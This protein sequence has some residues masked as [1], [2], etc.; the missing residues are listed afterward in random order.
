M[1]VPK[2]Y[3]DKV[4]A[5]SLMVAVHSRVLSSHI[6]ALTASCRCQFSFMSSDEGKCA[7]QTVKGVHS[8]DPHY[9]DMEYKCRQQYHAMVMIMDEVVGNIT[10][11]YKAK[12]MWEKTLVV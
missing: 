6:L 1:Q 8:I 5:A 3:Y 10:D 2:E 4:R 9:P 12:G 11:A 7:A